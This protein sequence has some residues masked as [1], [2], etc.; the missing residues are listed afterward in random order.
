MAVAL[1][2]AG[3]GHAVRIGDRRSTERGKETEESIVT[4]LHPSWMHVWH[5]F[6]D[7]FYGEDGLYGR[8]LADSWK[9][10]R[11]NVERG[12]LLVERFRSISSL[13]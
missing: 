5:N 3:H 7:D 13:G 6:A 4:R 10:I 11:G 9:T 12:E 2:L 8:M 1:P